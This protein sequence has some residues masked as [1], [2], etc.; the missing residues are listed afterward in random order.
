MLL[1]NKIDLAKGSQIEDKV[2]Y[3]KQQLPTLK[4]IVTVSAKT[5]KHVEELLPK[6]LHVHA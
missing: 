5:G 1:I 4:E 2:A 6:L 3:W